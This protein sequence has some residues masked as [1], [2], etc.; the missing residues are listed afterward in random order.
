MLNL[1]EFWDI[2][3]PSSLVF[4]LYIIIFTTKTTASNNDLLGL[5]R[6]DEEDGQRFLNAES[7]SLGELDCD[8]LF[9]AN[10]ETRKVSHDLG[11]NM[12]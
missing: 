4:I 5:K 10:Q 1:T 6:Q 8:W 9:T 3:I 2:L 11:K 12:A 7:I